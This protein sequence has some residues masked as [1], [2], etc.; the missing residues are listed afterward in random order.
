MQGLQFGGGTDGGRIGILVIRSVCL[1][2][3][4]LRF[5]D[6]GFLLF[7]SIRIGTCRWRLQQLLGGVF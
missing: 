5:F 3:Q 4:F 6:S 7:S 2:R 1:P